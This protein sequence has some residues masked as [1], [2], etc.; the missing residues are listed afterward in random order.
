MS[1]RVFGM[2]ERKGQRPVSLEQMNEA[3]PGGLLDRVFQRAVHV[4]G[5]EEDAAKWMREPAF[6]LS[7]R[8]RPSIY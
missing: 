6:G 3:L 8:D 5:S 7:N 4:M 2:L 1:P